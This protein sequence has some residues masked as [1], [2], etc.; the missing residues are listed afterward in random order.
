MCFVIQADG[1]RNKF[2]NEQRVYTCIIIILCRDM[3]VS[4]EYIILTFIFFYTSISSRYF[5]VQKVINFIIDTFAR[6]RVLFSSRTCDFPL[7]GQRCQRKLWV[8]K[9][10]EIYLV[11]GI[12]SQLANKTK[13]KVHLQQIFG[14]SLQYFGATLGTL[15][16]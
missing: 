13:I 5:G 12:T 16:V 7:Y 10:M 15:P 1:R 8:V 2:L 11:A 3:W 14:S 9:C 6:E 4:L